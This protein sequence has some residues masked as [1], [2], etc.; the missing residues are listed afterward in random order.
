[1]IHIL[2][3]LWLA[4]RDDAQSKPRYARCSGV[5]TSICGY[6]AYTSEVS[7]MPRD[8][9]KKQ[10][11]RSIASNWVNES[12]TYHQ[13]APPHMSSTGPPPF[14]LACMRWYSGFAYSNN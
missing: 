12:L 6:A 9:R 11:L 13:H 14:R 5:C 4:K 3:K 8:G 2:C 10:I 1:M 7:Y